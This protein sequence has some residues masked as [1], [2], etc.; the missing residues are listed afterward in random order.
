MSEITAHDADVSDRVSTL[1]AV[2]PAAG[3]GRRFGSEI[4][5]QY[6]ILQDQPIM[7]HSINRLF[8]LPLAGCVI[9]I[10]AGDTQAQTLDYQS[11]DRIQFV[12]GGAERMDSVLAGLE[13]L[14]DKAA[15][16]DWILV[17]DVARPCITPTSL[18]RLVNELHDHEIGGI[19]ATPVRD[20]LKQV[21]DHNILATIPRDN[22]WQAQTPQMFRFG[23]LYDALIAA[24]KQGLQ[25]TDEASAIELAGLS[26]K[27]VEGRMDNIKI[28]YA[29]DLALA[30]VI[31]QAQQHI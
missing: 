15:V 11:L 24:K 30:D 18:R 23:V 21:Q 2:V 4:P 17:H 6:L 1:W 25:V 5:K 28:T 26:V 29:D 3:S 19:L 10:A 9:A 31:L 22:L 7:L 12:V 8:A 16:D 14:K 27:I 13:Y 20:T